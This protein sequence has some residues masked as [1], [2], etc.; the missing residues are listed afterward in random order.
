[1]FCFIITE[2]PAII[3]LFN[4]TTTNK[5]DDKFRENTQLYIC[6]NIKLGASEM[7]LYYKTKSGIKFIKNVALLS[8]IRFSHFS[9][10]PDDACFSISL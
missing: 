6:S 1:M 5:N 9:P 10:H 7:I 2:L 4:I 8:C 3:T